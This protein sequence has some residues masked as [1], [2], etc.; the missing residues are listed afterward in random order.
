MQFTDHDREYSL[1]RTGGLVRDVMTLELIAVRE[2]K[3][4]AK[5]LYSGVG[6]DFTISVFEQDL[7]VS[8]IEHFISV[9]KFALLPATKVHEL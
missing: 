2:Q 7:P 5:I 9:A 6:R 4:V 8:V 3:S 1:T